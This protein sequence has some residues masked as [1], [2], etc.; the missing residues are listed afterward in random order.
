MSDWKEELR[1]LLTST[2]GRER[3]KPEG[4]SRVRGFI[5]EVAVPAFEE[6]A[7]E[8][9][10]YDRDVEVEHGDRSASIRVLKD[11]KE[12]FYYEIKV[13]AYRAKG[14]AFPIAPLRD[15]QGQTY[16]AEIHLRDRPLHQDVTNSTR[17]DLI[18]YFLHDYGRHLTWTL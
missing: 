3:P 14:F 10:E 11:G 5:S 1:T 15:P 8:L 17:E 6:L 4:P 13:R 16:R 2:E 9:Q 12:E 7:G 18:R